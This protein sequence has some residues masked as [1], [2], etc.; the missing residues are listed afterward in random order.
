VPAGRSAVTVLACVAPRQVMN[1]WTDAPEDILET[2]AAD[3]R[4]NMLT[5][6]V[7]SGATRW[8]F[9]SNYERSSWPQAGRSLT[10][11]RTSTAQHGSS[12]ATGP[13]SARPL[14]CM[15]VVP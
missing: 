8:S 10:S 11:V 5:Y 12:D 13:R 15:V 2:F 7:W 1:E 14:S 9:R 3:M 6:S 4:H